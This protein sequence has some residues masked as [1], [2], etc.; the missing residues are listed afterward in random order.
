MQVLSMHSIIFSMDVAEVPQ[1]LLQLFTFRNFTLHSAAYRLSVASVCCQW[2]LSAAVKRE[3][4]VSS[5]FNRDRTP[6]PKTVQ[7]KTVAVTNTSNKPPACCP[8]GRGQEDWRPKAGSFRS[9]CW[10]R[11]AGRHEFPPPPPLGY[12]WLIRGEKK[13]APFYQGNWSTYAIYQRS[14]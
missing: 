13:K 7:C 4:C 11:R 8:Q 10:F 12:S 3:L 2:E 14:C 6:H 5:A 9:A 1:I